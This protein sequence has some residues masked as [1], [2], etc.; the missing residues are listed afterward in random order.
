[1]ENVE[2]ARGSGHLAGTTDPFSRGGA[3]LPKKNQE[4]KGWGNMVSNGKE[5][6]RMTHLSLK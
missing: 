1:M 2:L 6:M 5:R 3:T 4:G